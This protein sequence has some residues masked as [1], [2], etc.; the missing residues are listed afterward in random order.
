MTDSGRI[1]SNIQMDNSDFLDGVASIKFQANRIPANDQP[2]PSYSP[3]DLGELTVEESI[4]FIEACVNYDYYRQNTDE[5]GF[6]IHHETFDLPL[7]TGPPTNLID[8]D[9]IVAAYDILCDVIANNVPTGKQVLISNIWVSEVTST[10][11]YFETDI[12]YSQSIP[13]ADQSLTTDDDWYSH[14]Y[15]GKCDA[16]LTPKD[17]TDRLEQIVNWYGLY[18]WG[19]SSA[20]STGGV[21]QGCPNNYV[22]HWKNIQYGWWKDFSAS[23]NVWP[24]EGCW[25][26]CLDETEME[27]QLTGYYGYMQ[28][29]FSQ[30]DLIYTDY[31]SMTNM[32]HSNLEALCE[33]ESNTNVG[34]HRADFTFGVLDCSLYGL[35]W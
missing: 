15:A 9:E 21:I 25:I 6:V 14:D 20:N 27:D 5:E 2:D 31:R 13:I 11:V 24:W 3:M 17:A 4:F 34:Y 7:V 28:N 22:G 26:E 32:V 23:P 33:N 1:E 12:T 30:Y 18:G 16:T 29:S 35:P 19:G 8:Q 10:T